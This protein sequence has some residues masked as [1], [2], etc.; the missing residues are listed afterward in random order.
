MTLRWKG[1]GPVKLEDA[2]APYGMQ[3]HRHDDHAEHVAL[4]VEMARDIRERRERHV[5]MGHTLHR[6]GPSLAAAFEREVEREMKQI[7]ADL[8]RSAWTDPSVLP[9]LE[10][11]LVDDEDVVTGRFRFHADDEPLHPRIT[12]G[13]AHHGYDTIV[14]IAVMPLPDQPE[15]GNGDTAAWTAYLRAME[16]RGHAR[17]LL[18]GICEG[19]W[20]E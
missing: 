2:L 20:S 1:G 19:V 11:I 3:P 7:A 16:R 4:H 12:V 5:A 9:A 18:A 13:P 14:E 17:A 8:E 6:P 15:L 10:A